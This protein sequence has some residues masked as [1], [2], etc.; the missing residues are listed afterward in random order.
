MKT[1]VV[2]PRL[3]AVAGKAD[4]WV[5]GAARQGRRDAAGDGARSM[6]DANTIDEPFLVEFT[7]APRLVDD[8]GIILKDKDSK[9]PLVWDT[10]TSSAK[11]YSRASSR[12]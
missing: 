12:R 8:G 5:P 9:T 11:P 6:I 4:E 7:N 3:S 10:V 2:E 1:V